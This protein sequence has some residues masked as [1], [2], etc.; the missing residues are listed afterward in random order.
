MSSAARKKIKLISQNTFNFV[1][2]TQNEAWNDFWNNV[3]PAIWQ[4]LKT[5]DRNTLQQA[6]RAAEG[7]VKDGKGRAVPL[8]IRRL[9]RILDTYAPGRYRF[10]TYIIINQ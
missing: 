10:E 2:M 7:K 4:D 6:R 1:A 8:G 3:R 9:K 5:A